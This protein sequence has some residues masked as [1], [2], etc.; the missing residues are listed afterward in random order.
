MKSLKL[1]FLVLI[2]VTTV[3][4]GYSKKLLNEY[5]VIGIDYSTVSYIV[6][7][8]EIFC[9][10]SGTN[11]CHILSSVIASGTPLEL[12]VGYEIILSYR[13]FY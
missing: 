1:L 9:A 6:S 12:P 10:G 2:L 8:D 3:T 13:G 11:P 5:W 4:N 7:T